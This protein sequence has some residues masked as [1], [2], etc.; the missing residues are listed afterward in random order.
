MGGFSLVETCVALAL[1][2]IVVSTAVG[3]A[4]TNVALT[5]YVPAAVE[6]QQRARAA[7]MLLQTDLAMAGAG[8]DSGGRAGPLVAWVPPILPRHAALSGGD[9]ASTARADVIAIDYVAA[10]APVMTT[11]AP[12]AGDA[13]T[14]TIAPTAGCPASATLCGLEKGTV[15]LVHDGTGRHALYSVTASSAAG[16]AIAALQSASPSFPAGA[17]VV[18]IVVREYSFDADA[19]QLLRRDDG[20][21]AV[22]VIDEVVAMSVEYWGDPQPPASPR[23]PLGVSNCLYDAAGHSNGAL[24]VLPIEGGSLAP[25]PLSM[26][27]DGPWCG[28][29]DRAFDVDLLRIRAVRIRLRVQAGV[30]RFRLVGPDYLHPGSAARPMSAV[31]DMS[32]VVDATPRNLNLGR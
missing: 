10:S 15:V 16:A 7:V 18:P 29:G 6:V 22:A 13:A 32:F 24:P 12:I 28:E 20:G 21:A 2:A 9:S 5:E 23:P 27:A 17:F 26:L 8:A 3:L 31:P 11:A 30:D 19:R 4:T 14:L 25:L 1:A